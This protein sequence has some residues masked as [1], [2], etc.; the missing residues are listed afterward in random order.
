MKDKDIKTI[1]PASISTAQA[2]AAI[3]QERTERAKQCAAEV[4]AVLKKY[5]CSLS[6]AMLIKH[7]AAPE[8]Q[9][10]IVALD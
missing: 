9:I 2:K 4:D 1:D 10:Q 3:E 5:N 7:G 6:G 8:L